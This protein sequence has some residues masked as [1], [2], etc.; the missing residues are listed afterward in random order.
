MPDRYWACIKIGG[1][2][3]E[4]EV[5]SFCEIAD[6]RPEDITKHI[7][8]GLFVLEGSQ[9][10]YGEFPEL[11]DF[12]EQHDLPYI[13]QSDGGYEWPPEKSF[14]TPETRK[15][16]TVLLDSYGEMQVPMKV[17]RS[18]RESLDSERIDE[19]NDLLDRYI[20]DLPELPAFEITA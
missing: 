9:Q 3:P 11:E 17:L 6:I 12:C 14:W 20:V 13:R 7:E 8:D 10:P 15:I 19:V 2:L 5:Q 16:E 4:C 18:L 1:G